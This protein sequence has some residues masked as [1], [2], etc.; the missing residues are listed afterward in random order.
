M[1]QTVEFDRAVGERVTIKAL[2]RQGEIRNV[3]M[4]R[5]G[6]QSAS[7]RHVGNDNKHETAWYEWD[8]LDDPKT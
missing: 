1:K 3:S 8:E 4:G 5:H 7:V 6:V 2:K